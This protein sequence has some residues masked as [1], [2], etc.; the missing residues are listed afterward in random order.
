MFSKRPRKHTAGASPLSVL[1]HFGKLLEDGSP[2]GK[3]LKC[4]NN[5]EKFHC[6]FEGKWIEI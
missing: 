1:S 6:H 5:V 3:E 2:N 4:F